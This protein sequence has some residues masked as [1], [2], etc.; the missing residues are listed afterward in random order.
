MTINS[1]KEIIHQAG[2]QLVTLEFSYTEKDGSNE[3]MREV[4]PYSYRFQRGNTLF[5]GFDIKKNGIRAFYPHKIDNIRLTG[6][7]FIPRWPIEV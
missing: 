6:N 2:C 4:E 5:F 1:I 3:G 7:K